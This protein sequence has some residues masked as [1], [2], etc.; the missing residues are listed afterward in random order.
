M[1]FVSKR[2][3]SLH[4][5]VPGEQPTDREYIKLNANENPYPPHSSV[6]EAV[7]SALSAAPQKLGLYPDPDVTELRT[8][9]A[10]MLN[11][12]GGVLARA[13]H[14]ADVT[15]GCRPAP[16]DELGF[17][18]T[19]D[20]IFCGNGSDEVLS[21]VFYTFFDSDRPVVFPEHTYSFYPVYCGYYH[22]PMERIKL[23]PD[24]RL[25]V[26]TML[27]SAA[28]SSSAMI[29]ANPNAPTGLA[30]TRNEVKQILESA[31]AGKV[32][33]VDEAYCDFGGESCLPLL[34]DHKNLV[35]VR[36]FS[37]SLSFAGM[38]LG[39]IVAAPELVQAV[40]CV[41]NSFN[42]FPVDFVAK[43]AAIASCK[44][45]AYYA[46]NARKIAMERESFTAFLRERG[47]FVL[48]SSTNFVFTKKD[49]MGGKELYSRAKDAGILI[50]H[51]ATPGIEDFVRISIGTH[52][53]ME[54][55]KQ[56]L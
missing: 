55:L 5:Y 22:I 56:V 34:K 19:P 2:L 45:A 11:T 21:F 27:A 13:S 25:D 20:M 54:A 1:E 16:E 18:I 32:V 51:F 50:R 17:E 49:G 36:T 7:K 6:I 48:D 31:P 53:Q 9:I 3:E 33:V 30:L 4:P 26:G 23:L 15:A 52:E 35:I 39:Y 12:T 41:K 40:F 47:Y 38:R 42:H 14:S 37:K 46:D 44:A 28:K 10:R 24:W 43:T 8:Q 29:F